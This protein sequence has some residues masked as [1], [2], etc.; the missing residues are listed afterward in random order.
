VNMLPIS[1]WCGW[2]LVDKYNELKWDGIESKTVIDELQKLADKLLNARKGNLCKTNKRFRMIVFTSHDIKDVGV[3]AVGKVISGT[4][5]KGQKICIGPN[6]LKSE[7]GS[8]EIFHTDR[9]DVIAG[10][11]IGFQ[12]KGLSIKEVDRGMVA[13]DATE[14][15]LKPATHFVA[16]IHV[17]NHPGTVRVGFEPYCYCHTDSFPVKFVE[18]T[19]KLDKRTGKVV[20]DNPPSLKNGDTGIVLLKVRNPICVE[21]YKNMPPLG[22]FIIYDSRRVV[23]V[24]IIKEVKNLDVKPVKP[25]INTP[26][27]RFIK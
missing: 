7:V 27:K 4:L 14:H 11:M 24:G 22:R 8:I 12:L 17:L 25:S 21:E 26:G 23:A 5:K 13:F 18:L 15:P 19:A 2:N 1:A 9:K 16:Q 6:N 3:V 20:E 10:D